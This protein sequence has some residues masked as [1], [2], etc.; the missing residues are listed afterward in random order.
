MDLVETT[1]E[2]CNVNDDLGLTMKEVMEVDCIE[3]LDKLLGISGGILEETF[4]Q[5]D[6]DLDNVV[7]KDE[8]YAAKLL[9]QRHWS[10]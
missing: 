5:L 6:V 9:R 8:A 4:S 3:I 2:V 7:S 10:K 1:F